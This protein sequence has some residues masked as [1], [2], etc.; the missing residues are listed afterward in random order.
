MTGRISITVFY[1]IIL[2]ISLCNHSSAVELR[3]GDKLKIR[4]A[5]NSIY[6]GRLYEVS[7]DSLIIK[8]KTC[9]NA[10][11]LNTVDS[12]YYYKR[13]LERGELAGGLFGGFLGFG[14]GLFIEKMSTEKYGDVDKPRINILKPIFMGLA[15]S[16]IG[17]F[18]GSEDSNLKVIAGDNMDPIKDC[19]Y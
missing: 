5:D 17:I 1:V 4:T 10:F 9:V 19:D 18:F 16:M 2:L 11:S 14:L 3:C 6:F 13:F 15:G 12:V 7:K 8:S